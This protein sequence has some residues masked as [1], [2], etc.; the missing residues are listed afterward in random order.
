[1]KC[2]IYKLDIKDKEITIIVGD[3][4]DMEEVVGMLYKKLSGKI[5][6]DT[7][8]CNMEEFCP[9]C[10]ESISW[11]SAPYSDEDNVEAGHDL[12]CDY[13]KV[14]DGRS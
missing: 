7:I 6:K 5:S 13:Y 8:E 1:M 2:R 12:M 14:E 4:E 11:T 9:L 10:K 3:N